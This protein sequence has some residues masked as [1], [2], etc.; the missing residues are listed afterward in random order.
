MRLTPCLLGSF[1]T[2]CSTL[3]TTVAVLGVL[4]LPALAGATTG[5]TG[6]GGDAG[7][8]GGAG[9]EGDSATGTGGEGGT[10]GGTASVPASTGEPMTSGVT[11]GDAGEE[12]ETEHSD[13]HDHDDEKGCSIGSR[14]AAPGVLTLA[15]LGL[16][17]RRRRPQS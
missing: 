15:L 6:G 2:S 1:S 3:L 17:G 11:T 12:T 4:A 5:P 14:G 13:D 8:G 7:S 9:S 16:H 10:G